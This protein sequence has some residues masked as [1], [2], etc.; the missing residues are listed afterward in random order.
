MGKSSN[1]S[2]GIVLGVNIASSQGIPKKSV[3][4]SMVN[5]LTGNLERFVKVYPSQTITP[6]ETQGDKPTI[7]ELHGMLQ[8][9][10]NQNSS[11][12]TV[13]TSVVAQKGNYSQTL[14]ARRKLNQDRI[15]DSGATDHMAG[16]RSLFA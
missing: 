11:S 15:V 12:S 13:G 9:L 3:G 7:R 1:K 4:T 14:A 6:T 16:D 8:N 10:M 2:K 5:L